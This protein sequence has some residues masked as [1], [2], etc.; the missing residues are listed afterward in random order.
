MS[1]PSDE[2]LDAADAELVRQ[3]DAAV[4]DAVR[5]CGPLFGCGPGRRDCCH[6]PFPIS[7]LDARRLQRGLAELAERDP[8]RAAAVRAR[9]EAAVKRLA[10]GFP[11]D[12]RTGLIADDQEAQQR[13][14]MRHGAR[15]CPA[16]DPA[17]GRCEV[18]EWRPVACRA[19]GPPVRLGGRDLAP[20]PYCFGP[21]TAAEVE[22]CR[23]TLDPERRG[24]ALNAAVEALRGRKGDTII[25]FALAGRPPVA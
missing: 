1:G 5:R 20:C 24:D 11:G 16:L 9:A 22:R 12:P 8:A 17:T 7:L 3:V 19:M 2:E 18:Y 6:G 25:A 4:A 13:F 10:R 21:A 23:A 15:M 14:C